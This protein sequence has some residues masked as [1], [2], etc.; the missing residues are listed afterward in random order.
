MVTDAGDSARLLSDC[1]WVVP[2][3]R[4]NLLASAMGQVINLSLEQRKALGDRSRRR[5][6]EHYSLTEMARAYAELYRNVCVS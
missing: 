5:V 6:Q 2:V 3:D 1:G 4:P